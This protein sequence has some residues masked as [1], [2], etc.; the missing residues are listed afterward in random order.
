MDYQSINVKALRAA[1]KA[2]RISYG[3]LDTAG[4]RAALEA[5]AAQVAQLSLIHI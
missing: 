5:H 3:S 4:M 2:A 1:C